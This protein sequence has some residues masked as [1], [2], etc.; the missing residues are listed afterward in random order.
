MKCKL[1]ST[2]TKAN[3]D[4]SVAGIRSIYLINYNS[5]NLLKEGQTDPNVIETIELAEG[6][7]A[8][9][10]EFVDNTASFTDDLAVNGNGGKYRTHTLNFTI[11]GYTYEKLN[12][13]DA[14]SLG[15]FTAVVVD[16]N[17][18][19][20]VLGRMNGMNATA[21]NYASGAAEADAVGWTVTM[22]GTETEMAKILKDE[23]ILEPIAIRMNVTA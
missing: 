21:M 4:Y 18:T 14:L 12:A 1:T 13:G 19:A 22:A 3:C 7:K 8:Y 17:G 6:E 5:A 11:D 23:K 20:I 16:K 10:V 9:K 15:K 2:I